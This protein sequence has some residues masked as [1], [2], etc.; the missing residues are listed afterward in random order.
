MN[1]SAKA[2][3]FKNYQKSRLREWDLPSLRRQP[4]LRGIS[5]QDK[6]FALMPKKPV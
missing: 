6:L 5:P 4:L 2:F 3:L 1:R